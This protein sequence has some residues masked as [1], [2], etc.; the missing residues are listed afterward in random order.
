M[1]LAMRQD[2]EPPSGDLATAIEAEFG[3]LADMQKKFNAGAAGVQD[4]RDATKKLPSK[5]ASGQG[6]HND[7]LTSL[8]YL[9][10]RSQ[11]LGYNK[12]TG[13]LALTTTANQ[14]CNRNDHGPPTGSS[15]PAWGH[16]A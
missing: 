11:W 15:S 12:A 13:K 3:S 2:F 5:L 9:C 7:T 6:S 14:V 8:G 4:L 16:S 1:G 10:P